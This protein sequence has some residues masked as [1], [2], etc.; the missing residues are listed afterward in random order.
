M[1]DFGFTSCQLFFHETSFHFSQ[2]FFS[3]N[4]GFD[5]GYFIPEFFDFVLIIFFQLSLHFL[6]FNNLFI[7]LNLNKLILF[8][9]FVI[10]RFELV[11]SRS[12]SCFSSL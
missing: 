12:I 8:M 5:G 2:S 4:I 11:D 6:S 9:E 1:G 7:Q 3:L 10:F